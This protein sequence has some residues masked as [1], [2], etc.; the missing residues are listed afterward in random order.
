MD[1]ETLNTLIALLGGGLILP[2][3][4]VLKKQTT[5]TV[6]ED[7]VRWELVTGILLLGLTWGVCHFLA[8]TMTI[9]E[10]VKLGLTATG[11]ASMV[12]GGAL[13]AKIVKNKNDHAIGG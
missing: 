6:M 9:A 7:Y 4:G 1:Q 12:Y 8:P 3:I 10:V 13:T 2:I 5:G 11:A